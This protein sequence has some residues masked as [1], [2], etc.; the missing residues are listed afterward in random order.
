MNE[1]GVFP[2]QKRYA[3]T[4]FSLNFE[5]TLPTPINKQSELFEKVAAIQEPIEHKYYNNIDYVL[6]TWSHTSFRYRYERIE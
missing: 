3:R 4:I 6:L 2:K 1:N 5:K